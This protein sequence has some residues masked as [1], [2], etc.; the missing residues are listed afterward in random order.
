MNS[1]IFPSL[2]DIY[3]SGFETGQVLDF[4]CFW[5]TLYST[6]YSR[7]ALARQLSEKP[8]FK[9]ERERQTERDRQTDRK[10]QTDKER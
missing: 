7:N 8:W 9:T 1:P 4:F 5:S 10:R 3:C 2:D 6:Y